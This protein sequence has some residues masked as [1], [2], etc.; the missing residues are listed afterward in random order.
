MAGGVNVLLS[1]VSIIASSRAR[2][3]SPDGRCKTF[4][5][6]ADGVVDGGVADDAFAADG[7]GAGF[8]LRFDQCDGP[9]A[10]DAEGERGGQDGGQADEAGVAD[11]GVD[12][13]GDLDGVEVAGVGAFVDDHARACFRAVELKRTSR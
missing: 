2:M 1:P 3:L 5:A 8:E 13:V 4:D 11:E 12:R 7:A 9:G 10:G 6:G